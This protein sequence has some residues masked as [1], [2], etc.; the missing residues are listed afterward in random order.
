MGYQTGAAQPAGAGNTPASGPRMGRLAKGY[1]H[2][3]GS[4][5]T[6]LQRALPDDYW[7]DLGLSTG[8]DA[9]ATT[10]S[11]FV[12]WLVM[13]NASTTF[14]RPPVV[15]AVAGSAERIGFAN[16]GGLVFM[17]ESEETTSFELPDEPA[18]PAR[19]RLERRPAD[20]PAFRR[21]RKVPARPRLRHALAPERLG[22]RWR[23]ASA[24]RIRSTL[25]P[26]RGR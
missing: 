6:S 26:S 8:D 2:T 10:A 1:W 5:L 9:A 17:D 13:P 3:S 21:G 12:S 22:T 20:L 25:K 24:A 16:S 15:V 11:A 14:H 19:L 7:R 23:S 4:G 18:R